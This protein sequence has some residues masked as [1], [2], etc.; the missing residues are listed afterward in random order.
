MKPR[1]LAITILV[2]LLLI[3]LPYC[4]AAL[5]GRGEYVFIGFLLN[6]IDGLSYLAKMNQGWMGEWRFVLPYTKDGGQGGYLF[7]FYIFLGHLSRWT[8][9]SLIFM[10]HFARIVGAG[11]LLFA[12][13]RLAKRVFPGRSDLS[14]KAFLLAACGAGLGWLVI[15]TGNIPFDLW[16]AEAYPFL[17]MYS[18]PHFSFG[19]AFIILSFDQL[20]APLS[21][22]SCF[23]VSIMGLAI[24]VIFPFG[25]VVSVLLSVGWMVWTWI[26][27]RRLF[28]KPVVASGILGGPVLLYQ[29]YVILTDPVLSGWN[30]QNITLTPYVVD[31]V[32]GLSPAFVLAVIGWVQLLRRRGQPERRLLLLWPALAFFLLYFPFS[33]QRR[34]SLGIFIPIAFLAVMGVDF[35]NQKSAAWGKWADR[36]LFVFSFPTFFL[37]IVSG[38]FAANNH[39]GLMY[40][41][42]NEDQ[43]LNW[44]QSNLPENSVILA[45]PE[46]SLLIPAFT[47]RRIIYAHPFETVNAVEEE[48]KVLQFYAGVGWPEDN[49]GYLQDEQVD[50]FFYGPRE[51]S[52]GGKLNLTG[53]TVV[54]Q[55]GDVLLLKASK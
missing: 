19:L 38:L 54:Y 5:I 44:I 49:Q 50:Y 29:Y 20:I 3:S 16:V 32:L 17:S 4:I 51:I 2:I 45:S 7:L 55:S 48:Q 41:T 1:A 43:A 34:F 28:W 42:K 40:L 53:F 18:S 36:L 39:P 27:T 15:F 46:M 25:V 52:L 11:F 24:S 8:G 21:W 10:Y 47:G 23:T 14:W 12:L 26:E 13:I 35:T 37:L 22:K 33:L 30:S 31:V 9:I 6:P